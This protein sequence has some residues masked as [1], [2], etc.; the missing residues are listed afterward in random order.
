LVLTEPPRQGSFPFQADPSLAIH[1]RFPWKEMLMNK[2][3]DRNDLALVRKEEL[4]VQEMADEVLVYD[5]RTNK[6]HG[7]NQT[8]A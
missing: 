8:T 3:T 7:L 6:A 4:V 2:A 5:L 1:T